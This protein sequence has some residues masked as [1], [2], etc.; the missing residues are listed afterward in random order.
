MGA[1]GSSIHDEV[2]MSGE[3]E[4][5]GSAGVVIFRGF[6]DPKGT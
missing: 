4:W 6:E 3:H 1:R 2:A 5:F